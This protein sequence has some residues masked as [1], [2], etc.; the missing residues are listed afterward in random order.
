VKTTASYSG[1]EQRKLIRSLLVQSGWTQTELA[2]RAGIDPSTLSRFLSGNQTDQTLRSSTLRRIEAIFGGTL[3][4]VPLQNPDPELQEL[5]EA[6]AEPFKGVP[7]ASLLP[8]FGTGSAK[9]DPWVLKSRALDQLG[10]LPGDILFVKLGAPALKGD[11]VCAQIYDWANRQAQTVFR[12][13]D[14]PYL[15]AATQQTALLRPHEVDQENVVIKGVVQHML[16]LC[17]R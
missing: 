15:L 2:K 1:P 16:R 8:E 5:N 7:L 12:L 11:V 14:P 17:R 6:E 13:F 10:Y 4:L 3:D 9:L